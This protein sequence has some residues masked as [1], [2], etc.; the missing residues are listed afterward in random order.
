M[1]NP[2]LVDG[3]E[4]LARLTDTIHDCW[5]DVENVRLKGDVLEI[6]FQYERSSFGHLL[7]S[8]DYAS[9][10]R[11]LLRVSDV[12]SFDIRDTEG[13]GSYNFDEVRFDP[14]TQQIMITAGIPLEF[15]VKV[16]RVHITC[17]RVTGPV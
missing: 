9:R 10:R 13:I 15:R 14:Q 17:E 6:P 2:I 8:N 7:S 4:Q 12:E 11:G 5:F 16:R 3:P 1:D